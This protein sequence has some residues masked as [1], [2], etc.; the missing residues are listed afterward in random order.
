M[1][2]LFRDS[3]L[4]AIIRWG[5]R[6]R[7]LKYP[8]E[9]P[10]WEC[11][12]VYKKP[13]NI[14]AALD[15]LRAQIILEPLPNPTEPP[16]PE[17][18]ER[19]EPEEPARAVLEKI[20]THREETHGAHLETIKTARTTAGVERVGTRAGLQQSRTRSDLEAAFTHATL[21]AGPSRPIVPATLDDGTILVDWYTTDDP[22]NP[23]NWSLGKKL[24]VTFQICS[25][26]MAVYM[27]SSIY[28]PG[29]LGIMKE[30]GV[31]AQLASMGLSMY[32]LAYGIGPMLWSP[33]SEI[34][35]IGRNPPYIITFFIFWILVIPSAVVDNFAG[36]I[37]LRFLQGFFGSPCL[38][39]GGA[40]L[41][42]MF[43][44]IKLPYVLSL[45]ALAATCGPSLGPLISGFS[46]TVEGWRW[47]MWELLWLAGPIWVLLFLCL[48]ETS[49]STILLRRAQRLRKISGDNRLKSQSEID[50]ANMSVSQLVKENLL[51]PNQMM[52]LDP[53]VGFTALYTSLI[54][55]IYY[56]FFEAFPLVYNE[57]YHFNLGEAG[58]AFLSITVGV[59]LSIVSYW[60]YV[61]F[62]MEPDIMKN[63]LGAPEKR[64]V[65]ALFASLLCP[66]GLFI[67][68]WASRP[69]IHYL[70]S[71]LGIVVFTGGIFVVLQCIFVYL[72]L[73]YPQYA[74]SLF[75]GND[76]CRS[77][78]G[79][80]AVH[81]AR[82]LYNNLG[83]GRGC[84]LLGG[85]TAGC[86]FGV[87]ALYVFGARLRAASRFAAK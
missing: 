37:V 82:P 32:V 28:A 85:L 79:C 53:A 43:S 66:A 41:Q 7:L 8:E 12:E 48:P 38:A 20:A 73:T 4:G 36:L 47:S 39:T 17:E 3:P 5:S 77:T 86:V 33:L 11:P 55:G 9:R 22:A 54:Y 75:A 19:E 78:L 34:P 40:S 24:F 2:D 14:Q 60:S 30:F 31:N 45:W 29:E 72:P 51:R 68:G 61:R 26:T 52:V 84:S 63:G 49:S 42:D 80:A 71:M 50:E 70:V 15:A 62:V 13:E 65:P 1:S 46:V 27:G 25:Y 87:Y 58:L 67:F 74:A 76:L 16:I 44:L 18:K 83:V 23:Q 21:A 81:F 56:S 6:G 10:D 35:S 57:M 69:D 64:L 59:F